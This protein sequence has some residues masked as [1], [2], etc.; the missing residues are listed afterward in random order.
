M[1][2]MSYGNCLTGYLTP[3][4]TACPDWADGSDDR[5]IG[6]ACH[7]PISECHHFAEMERKDPRNQRQCRNCACRDRKTKICRITGQY[8]ARKNTCTDFAWF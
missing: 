5:G 1:K 8:T 4:C 3:G 2:I 6:C 7:F